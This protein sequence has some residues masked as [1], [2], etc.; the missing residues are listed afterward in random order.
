MFSC[1]GVIL[2]ALVYVNKWL[3][4]RTEQSNNIMQKFHVVEQ[5]MIAKTIPFHSTHGSRQEGKQLKD[6]F[7]LPQRAIQMTDEDHS[8]HE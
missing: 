4:A 2:A 3:T 6:V 8:I 5:G 1:H 7:N